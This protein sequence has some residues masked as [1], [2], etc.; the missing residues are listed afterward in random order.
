MYFI[1]VKI[2]SEI[3]LEDYFIPLKLADQI[4]K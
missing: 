3:L 2:I 4:N 1:N